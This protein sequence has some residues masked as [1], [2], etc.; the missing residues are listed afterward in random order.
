M[1][2]D[3]P[4]KQNRAKIARNGSKNGIIVKLKPHV[5]K[6][7]VMPMIM[8]KRMDNETIKHPP[9]FLLLAKSVSPSRMS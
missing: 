1:F 9:R 4:Y 7:N 3:L 2:Y 5:Q 6:L 8:V